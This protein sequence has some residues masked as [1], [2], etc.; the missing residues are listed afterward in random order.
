[1][2][3]AYYK[4]MVDAILEK[5]TEKLVRSALRVAWMRWPGKKPVLEK[6]CRETFPK[7]KDG[8]R[9]KKPFKFYKCACCNSW[10]FKLKEV[11]VD[12]IVPVGSFKLKHIADYVNR[13]FCDLSNLQ[14]ICKKC[15]KV[16]NKL[17]NDT[18][19]KAKT[20]L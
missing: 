16:K 4:T 1:M 19:R 9:R 7:N 6:A 18:R 12:H 2:N 5:E 13:L 8:S 11:Q 10:E 3:T 14:V 15:H 17:E 20:L